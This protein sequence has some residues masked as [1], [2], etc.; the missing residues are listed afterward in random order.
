[1]HSHDVIHR[2]E[3]SIRLRKLE[4]RLVVD[5]V[6]VRSMQCPWLTIGEAVTS[7]RHVGAMNTRMARVL[8]RYY[9]GA[10]Q[11]TGQ[12]SRRNDAFSHFLEELTRSFR[13]SELQ[14]IQN[15]GIGMFRELRMIFRGYLPV[16]DTP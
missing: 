1:M 10:D 14:F 4:R 11:Y 6:F 5:S 3:P 15:L 8:C 2:W 9:Y 13:D 12:S 7:A 16:Q